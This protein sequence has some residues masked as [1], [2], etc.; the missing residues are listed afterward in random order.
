MTLIDEYFA[1]LTGGQKKTDK[2]SPY[3]LLS[4]VEKFHN[5]H[6]L[7]EKIGQTLHFFGKTCKNVQILGVKS[8]TICTFL[9]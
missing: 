7:G 4:G 3:V 5:L 8:I 1:N 2:V 6:L 9:G